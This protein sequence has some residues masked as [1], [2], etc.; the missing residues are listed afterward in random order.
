MDISAKCDVKIEGNREEVY[1]A[2]SELGEFLRGLEKDR[3]L[4]T[5]IVTHGSPV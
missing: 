1:T 4:K 3:K 2:L 5:D